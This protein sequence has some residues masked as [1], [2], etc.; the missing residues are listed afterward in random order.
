MKAQ[1]SSDIDWL[2]SLMGDG[3]NIYRTKD[4]PV[5]KPGE[6]KNRRILKSVDTKGA[7]KCLQEGI[8]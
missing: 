2:T 3:K 7:W 5:T 8:I 1:L 6:L 4:M